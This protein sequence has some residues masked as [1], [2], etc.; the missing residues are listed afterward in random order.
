MD[1]DIE[2]NGEMTYVNSLVWLEGFYCYS[3]T[4]SE[5][6]NDIP[7][8]PSIE[9][10]SHRKYNTLHI[11]IKILQK[12]M[13]K[14][15][16]IV[17]RLYYA[18]RQRI[19]DLKFKQSLGDDATE[20]FK[21]CWNNNRNWNTIITLIAYARW[22][23]KMRIDSFAYYCRVARSMDLLF[24][25]WIETDGGWA[26]LFLTLEFCATGILKTDKGLQIIGREIEEKFNFDVYMTIYSLLNIDIG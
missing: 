2:S 3:D 11:L 6:E 4:S 21:F 5:E 12:T 13:L 1:S 10:I 7:T 22:E 19:R 15:D 16:R 9:Y 26:P 25:E 14:S 23:G 18:I 17:S 20:F 24:S 8:Y